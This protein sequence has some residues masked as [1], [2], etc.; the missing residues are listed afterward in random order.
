M[1]CFDVLEYHAAS[2]QPPIY[3]KKVSNRFG[4]FFYRAFGW[5]PSLDSGCL[6]NATRF[7]TLILE[8]MPFRIDDT[9]T[10][11]RWFQFSHHDP[12]GEKYFKNKD[13]DIK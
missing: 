12:K 10:K 2:Q 5:Q 9:S 6:E 3:L 1:Y 7:M 13:L 8:G 4:P 11:I